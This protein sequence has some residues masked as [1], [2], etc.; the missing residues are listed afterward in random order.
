LFHTFGLHNEAP[1]V[2]S[3][4]T[5]Q[6]DQLFGCTLLPHQ[7]HLQR[8]QIMA[9]TRIKSSSLNNGNILPSWTTAG[10]PA[11]PQNGQ[12]GINTTLGYI[13]WYSGAALS[14]NP[15]YSPP[16]YAINYLIVAGGGGGGSYGGGGAGGLRSGTLTVSWRQIYTVAVGAGGGSS[17]TYDVS[18]GNGGNSA[19]SRAES[20][21]DLVSIGGGGGGPAIG[22][23]PASGGSGG[24]GDYTAN[25]PGTGTAG[26][27]NN[28]GRGANSPPN[29]WGGGGGGA[30]AVGAN[31]VLALSGTGGVGLSSSITGTATFYAGGGGGAVYVSTQARGPGGSGGGGNGGSW[32]GSTGSSPSLGTA[33]SANTGGGGGGRYVGGSGVVIVSYQNPVQ[34]GTGGT[35]SSYTESGTTFW[36]HTFTTSG[37]FTA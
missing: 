34:V 2:Q 16:A 14:W 7:E 12:M 9:R 37:T 28:G 26:Q 27:G 11:T 5:A 35:V 32:A 29:Y 3:L 23:A 20:S 6:A 17:T 30:G 4:V 25:T 18:G 19:I 13:E 31:G 21:I 36:V 10:R 1:V 33:G 22:A 24:G 15:I 8:K